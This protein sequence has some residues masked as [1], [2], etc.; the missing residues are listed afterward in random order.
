M[1]KDPYRH[2]ARVYDRLLEPMNRGLRLAGFR[3]FRPTPGMKIL[4]VGCGTG[5]HL[6]VYRRF[7]CGLYGIDA[8]ASMLA[9]ARTRLSHAAEV[10]H[11]DASAMPYPD[12]TFDFAIA[13][14]TLHEMD[15]AVRSAVM[16]ELKRVLREDGRILL[17]DFQPGRVHGRQG[18][19][20]KAIILLSELAAGRRHFRNY[21]RFMSAQGLSTVA[22]EHALFIEKQK[23]VAGG[24]L[25][26]F[27]V[28][29]G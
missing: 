9:L 11:G 24:T 3:M 10:C 19:F 27:L 22:A 20:S 28:R 1:R 18:W 21:R 29:A 23:V 15:P 25:A 2:V 14:L 13:M 26:L 17:I 5:A 8:S 7:G 4:D 12:G 16:R 6:D